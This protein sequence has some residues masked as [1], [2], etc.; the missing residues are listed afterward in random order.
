MYFYSIL[1]SCRDCH[2]ATL[3]AMTY[4]VTFLTMTYHVT[5]LA[6]TYSTDKMAEFP[7]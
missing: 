7:L 2:V 3:L 5:F 1:T 4:Y 6:M